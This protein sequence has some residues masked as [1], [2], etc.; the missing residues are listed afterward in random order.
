[1]KALTLHQPWASLVALGVKTIETRSWGTSYRGPLAI[2]AGTTRPP[3]MDL[4]PRPRG[5][6]RPPADFWSFHVI[7]TITDPA[8]QRP[9]RTGGPPFDRVP[10]RA[11]TP[12]L[13][14][15]RTGPYGRPHVEGTP[16]TEQGSA[17]LLPLGAVVA[18]CTL[19]DVRP[20]LGAQERL[21]Q[22]WQ[23]HVAPT[24][25]GA[26]WRWEGPGEVENLSTGRLLWR[27]ID[28]TDQLPF[29]D[30][31]PGRFAWLLADI[32]PL[33]EPIPARGYQGL[34]RWEP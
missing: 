5:R 25:Q 19:V 31:R 8:H 28:I 11:Q 10:K 23:P 26:L 30:Y 15:P 2:H 3:M 18:T 33:E 21:E 1:M 32:T 9:H 4:P 34:W 20:I 13:F 16:A 17:I 14:F 12:T 24:L 27:T 7:D 22:A 29:G 6:G